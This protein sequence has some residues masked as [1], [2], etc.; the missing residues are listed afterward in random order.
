MA[1]VPLGWVDSRLLL[2]VHIKNIHW[3]PAT[4]VNLVAI[5]VGALDIGSLDLCFSSFNIICALVVVIRAIIIRNVQLRN[6]EGGRGLL[7]VLIELSTGTDELRPEHAV[8]SL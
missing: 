7:P 2:L 6:I 4:A 5:F 3:Q 1:V 8:L